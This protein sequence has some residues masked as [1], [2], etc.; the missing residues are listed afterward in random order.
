MAQR[1]GRK[2][3]RAHRAKIAELTER[4]RCVTVRLE[5]ESTER[6]YLSRGDEPNLGD[7]AH[8]TEYSV[9]ELGGV[10]MMIERNATV[11]VEAIEAVYEM[12]RNQT[13][14]QFMG[15]QYVIVNGQYDAEY[16]F[17]V[18]G[19]PSHCELELVGIA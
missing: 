13:P 8:V 1:Y 19:G 5:R 10:G 12:V 2:Q 4:L 6:M 17:A 15:K 3:K 7:L 11:T 9:T 18:L 16:R 14:V